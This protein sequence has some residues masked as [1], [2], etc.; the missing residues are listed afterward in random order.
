MAVVPEG[1]AYC[2]HQRRERRV[3]ALGH[4]VALDDA[5]DGLYLVE[6]R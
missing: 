5:E 6:L 1:T 4:F 2:R 3:A